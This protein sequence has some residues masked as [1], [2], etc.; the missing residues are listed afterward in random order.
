[1]Y[2][3][4]CGTEN[5]ND[6]HKCVAC[7]EV[8]VNPQ[9]YVALTKPIPNYLAQSIIVT[10]CCCMPLGIPAIVFAAQANG[11]IQGGDR[12]G[13]IESSKNAKI[14]FHLSLWTGLA[15]YLLLFLVYALEENLW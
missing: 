2:C 9:E 4:R 1:M 15:S 13:A 3:V 8:L 5:E 11:K 7:E 6:A 14:F 12:K 10:L